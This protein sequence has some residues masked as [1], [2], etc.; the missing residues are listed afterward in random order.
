MALTDINAYM[1]LPQG[2][3]T[4]GQP[5]V[6][7]FAEIKAAGYEGVIN[8]AMPTSENWLADEAEVVA[9]LGMEYAPLPVLWDYPS[10]G[11]AEQFFE[12]MMQ[13]RDRPVWVHCALNMR[14]SAMM[15]LYHRIHRDMRDLEATQYLNKV[16][17]PN[18]VWQNF[19][20]AVI[21]LYGE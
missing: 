21:E 10:L 15:Y 12:L 14:V 18:G 5:T 2:I 4:S 9:G 16:W 6:E 19:M 1:L 11:D 8:L 17:I 20:D 3:A 7:Q 13:Y